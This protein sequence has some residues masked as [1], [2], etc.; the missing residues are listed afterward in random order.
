MTR[1]QPDAFVGRA[2]DDLEAYLRQ[3][4]QQALIAEWRG[5]V[6]WRESPKAH[7]GKMDDPAEVASRFLFP[8]DLGTD[9]PANHPPISVPNVDIIKY[10]GGGQFGWVYA[11]K[12]RTTGL[13]VALK[14]LRGR[15]RD[16]HP[17]GG[18]E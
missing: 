7:G 2:V 18:R 17:A 1:F 16:G 4:D 3:V 5:K 8:D 10:L 13:V 6:D 11:A 14:V 12:V 9:L 15:P